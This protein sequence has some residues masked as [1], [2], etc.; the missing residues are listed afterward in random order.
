MT[1]THCERR[2]SVSSMRTKHGVNMCTRQR[3]AAL[4]LLC[5]TAV[6]H[7]CARVPCVHERGARAPACTQKGYMHLHE[8]REAGRPPMGT[9]GCEGEGMWAGKTKKKHQQDKRARVREGGG[10]HA[11]A[12]KYR[13]DSLRMRECDRIE[14]DNDSSSSARPSDFCAQKGT[15]GAQDGEE[16]RGA[17]KRDRREQK[18]QENSVSNP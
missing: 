16:H 7:A 5:R 13:L 8:R 17:G 4:E 6:K 11:C 3:E 10:K 1:E 2:A 14:S 15:A 12:P 9:G 18:H